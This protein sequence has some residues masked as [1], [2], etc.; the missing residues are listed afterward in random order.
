M[1]RCSTLHGGLPMRRSVDDTLRQLIAEMLDQTSVLMDGLAGGQLSTDAWQ[2]AMARMLTEHHVA[3]YLA[4]RDTRD[5]SPESRQVLSELVGDQLDYLNRF[6]DDIDREGWQEKWR[7]R[8]ALYAGALKSTFSRAQTW[9][10]PLP[11]YPTEGSECM[12]NCLCAWRID[13]LDQ[14]NLDA[15]A[16]WELGRAEQHCTTCP[17]RAADNPYRIRGGVLL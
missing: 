4:G 1:Q 13:V 16:Y 10:W 7:A 15:D 14:E 17:S 5:L 8:G 9:A 3:S 2:Q 12:V 11:F 6:A